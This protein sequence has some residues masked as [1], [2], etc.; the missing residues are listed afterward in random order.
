MPALTHPLREAFCSLY[1]KGM[2]QGLSQGTIFLQAGGQASTPHSADVT[3]SRWLKRPDVLAR[4]AELAAPAIKKA[5]K[6]AQLGTEHFVDKFET[7]FQGASKDKQFNAAT[8]A[9]ELQAR[10]TG[11]LID[12][13][14]VNASISVETLTNADDVVAEAAQMIAR[15]CTVAEARML[16]DGIIALM[17]RSAADTAQNITPEPALDTVDHRALDFLKPPKWRGR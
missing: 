3:A 16:F 1:A 17:E 15:D 14:D 11:V 4:I 12:R 10:V 5:E 6:R 8:R 2:A 13:V 9:A 7:I